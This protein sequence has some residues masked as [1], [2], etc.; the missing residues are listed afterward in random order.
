V[1]A[2]TVTAPG[3]SG[4]AGRILAGRGPGSSSIASWVAAHY[5]AQTVG[6]VAVY[7][8]TRPP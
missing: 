7:D 2:A 3:Y 4:P 6:G 1:S 8:L 5:T